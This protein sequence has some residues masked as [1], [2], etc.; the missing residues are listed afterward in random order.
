MIV[1]N[2]CCL[3][4]FVGAFPAIVCIVSLLHHS[5]AGISLC[6]ASYVLF[7]DDFAAAL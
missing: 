7:D 2:A 5:T 4:I 1:V 6:L 3:F